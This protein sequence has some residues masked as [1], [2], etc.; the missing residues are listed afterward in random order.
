MHVSPCAEKLADYSMLL[1]VPKLVTT[2]SEWYFLAISQAMCLYREQ[3][4][5]PSEPKQKDNV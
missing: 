2:F 1:E 3:P 4:G 5:I